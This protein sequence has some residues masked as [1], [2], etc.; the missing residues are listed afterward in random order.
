ME[1]CLGHGQKYLAEQ[2]GSPLML[3]LVG[4]CIPEVATVQQAWSIFFTQLF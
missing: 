3:G 4:V 1:N 2:C